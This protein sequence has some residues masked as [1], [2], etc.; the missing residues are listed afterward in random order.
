MN[1]DSFSTCTGFTFCQTTVGLVSLSETKERTMVITVTDL[2][3]FQGSSASW[4]SSNG[5]T[6]FR[7]RFK[8]GE[9]MLETGQEAS[10]RWINGGSMARLMLHRHSNALEAS[11]SF[12][13][14]LYVNHVCRLCRK[15]NL[16]SFKSAL[17]ATPCWWGSKVVGFEGFCPADQPCCWFM[18][19]V[20]RLRRRMH[21][22]LNSK[23]R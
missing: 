23:S 20:Q 13:T 9:W 14:L 22:C 4:A 5:V 19:E 17:T 15:E 7:Q 12:V 1:C 8:T 3:F 11:F 18:K 10:R 6:H 2:H 21:F 16:V